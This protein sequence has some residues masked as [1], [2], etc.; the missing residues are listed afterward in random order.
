MYFSIIV[1]RLYKIRGSFRNF[2]LKQGGKN[3]I[4]LNSISRGKLQDLEKNFK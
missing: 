1:Q 2:A 3:Q 4:I